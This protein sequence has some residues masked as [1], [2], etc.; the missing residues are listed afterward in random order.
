MQFESICAQY[1]TTSNPHITTNKNHH[2]NLQHF[3]PSSN[4]FHFA[5]KQWFATSY[6]QPL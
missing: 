3:T 6:A 1:T 4:S 5:R 2:Y